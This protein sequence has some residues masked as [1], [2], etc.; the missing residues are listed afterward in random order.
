VM[1]VALWTGTGSSTRSVSGLAFSP[2]FVWFKSRSNSFSHNLY[3]A[4]RGAGSGKNLLTDKTEAEG[5]ESSVYGY[6]SSFDSTG[7]SL[8]QGSNSFPWG[9]QTNATYVAWCWDAGSSTVTNTAGSISSQVRANASA[10]FSIVTYTGTGSNATIGHGLGVAPQFFLIKRRN[11]SSSWIA[12]H[13]SIGNSDILRLES[14]NATQ[15][16]SGFWQNTRPTSSLIY[17]DTDG[18]VN[19]N[20]STYVCY[21]FAP[22]AGYSAFGSYTGNG[23]SDGPFV[24]TGFRP[25]F[26]LFKRTDSVSSGDW[27]IYDS[28][29][30]PYNVCQN[31]LLPN[32]SGAE[33][34]FANV[35]YLSNGFKLKSTG[36]INTSGGTWIYAAFA[37]SPFQY[38]RAR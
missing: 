20:G 2:E 38:A 34:V 16:I 12:W 22:V 6:I 26:V 35:D 29:R 23:S 28:A 1:D 14:T 3:D 11:T 32:T 37:E 18:T 33:G 27:V 15:T 17:L 10:G 19:A 36:S 5:W 13:T 25:R 7:F 4:V 31:Y 21:A 24:Y 30:D 8:A 9:N